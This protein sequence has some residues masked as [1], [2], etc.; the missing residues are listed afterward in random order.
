MTGFTGTGTVGGSVDPDGLGA[1][2]PGFVLGVVELLGSAV[3]DEPPVCSVSSPSSSIGVG[4]ALHA[5]PQNKARCDNKT[6]E[7]NAGD[8]MTLE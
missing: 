5:A 8:R 1:T 3:V 2:A 6:T 4:G 7:W